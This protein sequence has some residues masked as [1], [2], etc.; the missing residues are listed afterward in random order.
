MKVLTDSER[1]ELFRRAM[2]AILSKTADRR[3]PALASREAHR[4]AAETLVRTEHP[5]SR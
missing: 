5:S 1:V 4:I 2:L 3:D